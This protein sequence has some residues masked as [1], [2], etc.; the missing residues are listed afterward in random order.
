MKIKMTALL[1]GLIVFLLL[2]AAAEPVFTQKKDKKSPVDTMSLAYLKPFAASEL[3]K[4]DDMSGGLRILAKLF[5]D[6]L[7]KA[8][9]ALD[10]WDKEQSADHES[11]F[12]RGI[13][14]KLDGNYEKAE[15][16]FSKIKN[17]ADSYS[18]FGFD[19][20]WMQLGDLFIRLEQYDKAIDAFKQGA[21]MNIHD[22]WPLIRISMTYMEM[23][24]PEEASEAFYAGL[25][26]IQSEKRITSLFVDVTDIATRDE[27]T[28]WDSL[29]LW[30]EKKNKVIEYY[31]TKSP[32]SVFIDLKDIDSTAKAEWDSIRLVQLDFMKIFWKRRDPNPTDLVNERLVEHYRRLNIARTR[33]TKTLSPYYDDRGMVYVRWGKPDV[34]Y[35]GKPKQSIR[36]NETWVY[37]K[38]QSGLTLDFVNMGAQFEMRSL[39]EAVDN[40]ARTQDIIDMFEERSMY[41]PVYMT[42]AMKIRAQRDAEVRRIKDE[43]R[44]TP[45]GTGSVT[46][47]QGLLDNASRMLQTNEYRQDDLG[48]TKFSGGQFFEFDAG[49]PHLPI[50]FNVASFRSSPGLSRLEF[51]YTIPFNQLV[52]V[53][54]ISHPDKHN[55]T[56]NLILKAY[57]PKYNE[58]RNVERSYTITAAT[59]EKETHFFLDQLVIDSLEPGKYNLALDIRNN[60]KDRVGIYQFMISVRDYSGDTLTVSN[61]EI[62]QYVESTLSKDRYL[63]PKSNLRVVPNP[64]AGI[65]R[66]KPLWIYYEIYNLTLNNEGKSSYQVSYSIKM[67]EQNQSFL[68][69]VAGLFSSKQDAGT[70]SIT[71]KEGKSIHEKEYIAFDVSELPKGVATLEVRIKD[72]LSGRE[73][74]S[75]INLT[76][77]EEEKKMLDEKK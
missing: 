70:S 41:H 9:F 71:T 66:T 68:S 35:V 16:Q 21:L 43:L 61:V 75:A 7:K 32:G 60:E 64:A 11:V 42:L 47:Y 46:S 19:N 39:L 6:Q 63:K 2:S 45:W 31:K 50:N 67:S 54:S 1:G 40:S 77:I 55:T 24:K 76:L 59:T 51:Y 37:D 5:G 15:Q 25:N 62:A 18:T 49:A 17:D 12:L 8:R 53:P 72:M 23:N 4:L 20:I 65:V 38:I 3:Q 30:T 34:L 26:D 27:K 29:T 36:E 57:D 22:T 52:F 73:T 14:E 69:S 10:R 48:I 58:I 33:Y 74:M 56:L 13:L 44:M 28:K